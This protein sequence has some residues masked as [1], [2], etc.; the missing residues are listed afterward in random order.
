MKASEILREV[1]EKSKATSD[2]FDL[3]SALVTITVK[4]P[5]SEA[6]RALCLL[7]NML[8][9]ALTFAVEAAEREERHEHSLVW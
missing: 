5:V 6:T 4:E 9:I 3:L 1:L 8:P 2:A 7:R